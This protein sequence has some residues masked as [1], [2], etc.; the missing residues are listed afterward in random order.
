MQGDIDEQKRSEQKKKEATIKDE[1]LLRIIEKL[2]SELMG[3]DTEHIHYTLLS[4]PDITMNLE[5]RSRF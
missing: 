1:G 3:I 4:M 5:A 2:L